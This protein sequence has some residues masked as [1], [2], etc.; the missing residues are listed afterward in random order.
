M[1][2]HLSR[3]CIFKLCVVIMATLLN[4]II[5]NNGL[6][7]AEIVVEPQWNSSSTCSVSTTQEIKLQGSAD[8]TCILQ[9]N[10]SNGTYIQVQ[11]PAKS[12][13]QI[14]RFPLNLYFERIGIKNTCLNRYVAVGKQIETCNSIIIDTNI[15]VILQGNAN[16]FIREALAIETFSKCHRQNE[17]LP[18]NESVS[19]VSDCTDVREYN[20]VIP[21]NPLSEYECRVNIPPNCGAILGPR[22]VI[23]KQC[24]YNISKNHTALMMYQIQTE[25]LDL[26]DNNIVKINDYAFEDLENIKDLDLSRNNLSTLSTHALWGLI[27]LKTLTLE[28]NE[29]TELHA[30]W[31]IHL[32]NVKKLI[33]SYNM[34]NELQKQDFTILVKLTHLWLIG[35][36]IRKID[37]GV[38]QGLSRLKILKLQNNFL[39]VLPD[40]IFHDLYKLETLFLNYNNISHLSAK[41]FAGLS[42]L[43]EVRLSNN[44]LN[45]LPDGLFQDSSK[46]ETLLLNHNNISHLS[47]KLFVGLSKLKEVRLSNNTLNDLPGG[48]FQDSSEMQILRIPSNKIRHLSTGLLTG[49]E[50]LL[51]LFGRHNKIQTLGSGLFRGLTSLEMIHLGDNKITILPNNIFKGLINLRYLI[52]SVNQIVEID[53]NIFKG[54][55]N[56]YFLNLDGS[57]LTH[58]DD[59]IFKDNMKMFFLSLENN[60]FNR[61]PNMKY[62]L[63]LEIFKLGGNPLL[64]VNK[65]S[66]ETLPNN[67]ILIVDQKVVCE[68]FVPTHVK[69]SAIK[70]RSP[71]LTCD[72]LLSDRALV[73]VMWLIGLGALSGNLFVL[74]SRYKET[75]KRKVNS[76]LLRNLAASDLLMGIYML[77]IACADIYFGD[78]FPMVSDEWRTGVTCKILGAISIVS[79]EAS[80]FFV[81]VISIDRFIAIKFPYSARKLGK[82]S[83]KV[84]GTMVWTI[85]LVLGITP[86]VLSGYH[87]FKFYA[88]SHVCIGL[89]LAL[90]KVYFIVFSD[91]RYEIK[92]AG[93]VFRGNYKTFVSHFDRLENGLYFSTALFLGVNCVCY[94]IILACYIEIVRAVRE[95]SKQSGRSQE[96]TEQIRLTM[97]VT[98]IVATDFF[99]WFPVITLGIL[100]QIRVIELP[101]SVY[102]WCV[103]FVL[104]INSAINPYL[105]TIVEVISEYWKKRK[106]KKRKQQ[107]NKN[108]K[109]QK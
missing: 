14:D 59:D 20:E 53:E 47:G 54:L 34:L 42:E 48:L 3:S 87:S 107:Q 66:F 15:K 61:I 77:F 89:P 82:Y 92:F 90:T 11:T 2:D 40:G 23:Y 96:M 7:S 43:K 49:L 108:A 64:L 109:Q 18:N 63:H 58:L 73:F 103:T 83:V 81:T 57:R 93:E 39:S 85:S 36:Q 4:N 9:V 33:L 94:L 86:S 72:R 75:N 102:A 68:C 8:E 5:N 80:V 60:I 100:V 28:V 32:T 44:A 16:L 106:E 97:K 1:A 62:L 56:L 26:S 41:L 88:N 6:V 38:F 35:N 101:A 91:N 37:A 74:V 24:N 78:N 31:L 67:S 17:Y 12:E 13:S 52:L 69:C 71:Y 98:S 76:I 99:C 84:V 22:E 45:E 50:N 21:C 70:I 104:P 27:N 55:T 29:I 65:N 30:E 25:I 95:S 19:Q 51:L 46:M 105:Y 10:S 79:S